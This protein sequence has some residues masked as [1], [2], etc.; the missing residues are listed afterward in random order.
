[1]NAPTLGDYTVIVYCAQYGDVDRGFTMV[2][3]RDP[4]G[5]NILTTTYTV[6]V[7]TAGGVILN[8]Q[9]YRLTDS[10][11]DATLQSPTVAPNSSTSAPV[12]SVAPP[13]S[14]PD[15]QCSV[16]SVTGRLT[17]LA[18]GT[19]VLT[20]SI[21]ADGTYPAISD[22]AVVTVIANPYIYTVTVYGWVQQSGSKKNDKSLSAARAKAVRSYLRSQGLDAVRFVA[23]GKGIKGRTAKARSA[24]VV[25]YWTGPTSGR[26]A[27]TVYFG[28]SSSKIST[29]YKRALR[30]LWN[31]VPRD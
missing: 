23:L 31:R 24:Y 10:L 20:V 13:V 16:D 19:C 14:G 28:S 5:G 29:K 4:H 18:L 12:Y 30:V 9:T 25:I 22:T 3:L 21:A 6:H 8:D 2:D 17:F 15:A 7:V 27:T 11:S 26:V 1:V